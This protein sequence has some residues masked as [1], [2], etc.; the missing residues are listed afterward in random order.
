MS[1]RATRMRLYSFRKAESSKLDGKATA[2]SYCG[3]GSSTG[4]VRMH[5][6]L[7][8][9]VGAAVGKV[10]VRGQASIHAG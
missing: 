1:L 4:R 10:G 8:T 7:D 9:S 6:G 2:W 5:G 3:G